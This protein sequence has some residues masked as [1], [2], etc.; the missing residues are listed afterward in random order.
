MESE[1]VSA[2][3]IVSQEYHLFKYEFRNKNNSSTQESKN[4]M[5]DIQHHRKNVEI[6]M[7]HAFCTTLVVTYSNT[8]FQPMIY[9]HRKTW[10]MIPR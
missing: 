7:Q 3:I 5:S 9:Y 1:P 4:V 10:T 8:T 6:T 2:L